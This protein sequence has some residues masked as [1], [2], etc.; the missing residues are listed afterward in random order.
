MKFKD[1]DI[2]VIVGRFQ[3]AELHEAHKAIINEV[4]TRH[5][6][7]IIFIGVSPTLGTK[8]SPLDFANR[9]TMI[10]KE[11]PDIIV[12]PL[13]DNKSDMLWSKELDR[14]IKTIFPIGTVC[15]YGGRD[16]FLKCYHGNFEARE[17]PA[18]DYR[19]ATDIRAEIG[20]EVK[21][22][23]DFRKGIIYS[24]Q[25]QYPRIHSTIDVAIINENK[26]ILLATKNSDQKEG[27]K[28]IYRF[29]GGFVDTNETLE[30]AVIR[31]AQEETDICIDGNLTF[32]GSFVIDDWRYKNSSD[33]I[34]TSFFLGE[35][36]FGGA[37][38]KAK[39]DID[40]VT[41]VPI[42]ELKKLVFAEGHRPLAEKLI[43]FLSKKEK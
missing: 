34:L 27:V 35:Y 29:I 31:E 2:G 12:A 33:C 21:D 41:W 16:S 25:N 14:M 37:K 30:E 7:C 4:A 18:G 19:S 40:S 39:D 10:Q 32:L 3:I 11:F 1:Y 42:K 5:K 9:K 15:L 38:S 23:L 8:E 28:T 20:K 17:F 26:E 22:S 43:A 13:L 6:K 36:V 24:T